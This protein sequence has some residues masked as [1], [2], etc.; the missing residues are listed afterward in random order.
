MKRKS[1]AK[2]E[3]EKEETESG[4]DGKCESEETIMIRKNVQ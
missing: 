4:E 2:R 3:C 1:K